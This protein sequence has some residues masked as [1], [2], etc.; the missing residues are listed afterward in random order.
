MDNPPVLRVE[1]LTKEFPGVKA[2]D[3]VNFE[4]KAGRIHALM[5][6]NGAGKSTLMKC[7]FGLY[8]A[9]R[10][11]I[12]L[13][14]K[15]VSFQNSRQAM[16]AGISMV[17]QELQPI[18]W[19]SIMEN[20]WVGRYQSVCGFIDEKKLVIKTKSL[21]EEIGMTLDPR[22][23]MGTLSPSQ[24][25]MVAIAT[26]V[27]LNAK[28]I[29]F[30]EPTSSLS[31]EEIEQLFRVIN[32]LRSQ[33][34][35]IIYISH[36]M[37]EILRISDDVS[38]MRDGQ[39]IGTYLASDL[40]SQKIIQLMVGRNITEMY[41]ELPSAVNQEI[42]LEV[43]DFSSINPKSFQKV[44]FSL[45]K[46]EILGLG[47]LVGAQRTELMEALFGIRAH[48]EGEI[49]MH[50][51]RVDINSPVDAKLAGLA[52]LTEERRSTGIFPVLS[53]YD[54]MIIA[55]VAAHNNPLS[56]VPEKS[57]QEIVDR[58][59]SDL[60]VKTPTSKTLIRNLS[61]GNQ[62][63]VLLGRW[64][65]L[66]PDVLILDEPTRGIDVGAKHEIYVLMK[67]FLL[68]GKSIIMISSEMPEL[69]GMSHRVMV[70]CAGRVTGTVNA[71]TATQ[72]S[73]MSL[74]AQ[75]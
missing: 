9:D 53:V 41:P 30:D 27:S 63:K 42:V 21:F 74:A 43:K 32:Q 7:L 73:V 56:V 72:E 36:K 68:K 65:M 1:N 11:K 26:A 34:V 13:E 38:I 15:P 39:Y 5:G 12:L 71:K 33:G 29:I 31:D 10:G 3:A 69:I 50:G 35:A 19:R 2:L 57:M 16:D 67:E 4:F 37:D 66:H 64:L 14:G 70:M 28:V 48:S 46:G 54:N 51:K 58:Y 59:V 52:F 60:R 40:T 22:I 49:Y 6:E 44:T 17:Q 18:P 20:I 61:G 23:Q 62:Q 25:Q 55:D 8:K 45:R 47:G 24:M 75:F